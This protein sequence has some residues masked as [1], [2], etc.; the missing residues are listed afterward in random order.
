MTVAVKEMA[1]EYYPKYW[2][3]D[4][5]KSLVEN[6]KLFQA[7]YEEIVAEYKMKMENAEIVK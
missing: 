5:L 6:G 4:R 2:N 3:E 7:D 1:K